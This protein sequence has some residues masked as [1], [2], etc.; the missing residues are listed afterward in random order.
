MAH[1]PKSLL[2]LIQDKANTDEIKAC[3][4]AGG[5]LFE[6]DRKGRT[7][8]HQAVIDGNY[9]LVQHLINAGADV[10]DI[11][12]EGHTVLHAA[13]FLV[14]KQDEKIVR[15]LIEKG[16]DC[17]IKNSKGRTALFY[18]ATKTIKDATELDYYRSG[19]K[20]LVDA[21]SDL[22][23]KKDSD[24]TVLLYL[25]NT[26]KLDTQRGTILIEMGADVSIGGGENNSTL[27]EHVE[28]GDICDEKLC[29][30][31]RKAAKSNK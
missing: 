16:A 1:Q 23:E 6:R 25:Y 31:I 8:L 12:N 22:N 20:S 18:M 26:G 14:G 5:D 11:D 30:L 10:N 13:N 2:K 24:E 29:E 9:A 4:H 3:I 19:I 15:L 17:S 21:G 28:N 27:I 7:P